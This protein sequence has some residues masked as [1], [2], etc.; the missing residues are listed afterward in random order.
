MKKKLLMVLLA[1]VLVLGVTGCSSSSEETEKA[2]EKATTAAT[3]KATEKETEKATE[4]STELEAPSDTLEGEITEVDEDTGDGEAI[5]LKTED[6]KEYTIFTDEAELDLDSNGLE[7]GITVKVTLQS[8]EATDGSFTATKIVEE[9]DPNASSSQPST[10]K[11]TEKQTEKQTQSQT[12]APQSES[13]TSAPQ[14]ETEYTI[15]VDGVVTYADGD[16]MTVDATDGN[17]YDFMIADAS[18][19]LDSN[20]LY[21]GISVEVTATAPADSDGYYEASDV[22]ETDDPEAD[23]TDN[24]MND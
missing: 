8:K 18:L 17:T 14:S 5:V 13:Q 24:T 22:T 15:T 6:G 16:T 12:S 23:E 2:T 20:G 19:D 3:E 9:D 7:K 4:K 1:G 21:E 11:Q 10:T